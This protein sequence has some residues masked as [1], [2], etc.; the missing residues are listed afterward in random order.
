MGQ[1]IFKAAG[2]ITAAFLACG[3]VCKAQT[4]ASVDPTPILCLDTNYAPD[5]D[6]IGN[7]VRS[8]SVTPEKAQKMVCQEITGIV[9]GLAD[10]ENAIQALRQRE[11]EIT[12]RIYPLSLRLRIRAFRTVAY[13]KLIEKQSQITR[14]LISQQFVEFILCQNALTFLRAENREAL[15]EKMPKADPRMQDPIWRALSMLRSADIA[16]Q[17]FSPR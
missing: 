4:E 9:K 8:E 17:K 11:A 16:P 13:P 1:S 15:C 7:F 12:A 10:A 2:I 6:F 5:P 14:K 3:G